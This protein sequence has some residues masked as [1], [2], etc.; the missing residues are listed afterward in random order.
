MIAN[1]WMQDLSKVDFVTSAGLYVLPDQLILVRLRKNFRRVSLTEQEARELPEGDK[2]EGISELTGWIAEDVREIA[3]KSGHESRERVLRQALLSLMPHFNAARD[4]FFIC[5]PQEQAII[6]QI[7]LPQAAE[8]NLQEVLEYEIERYVPFRREDIYY[9]FLP[10]AKKGDKIGIFLFAIPKRELNTLLEVLTSFGIK[11]KGVETT[12]TALANYLLFCTADTAV[13]ATIVGVHGQT[14]ELVGV[15]RNADT[16]KPSPELMFSHSL[17]GLNG[18]Q[19]AKRDLLQQCIGKAAR[20]Y[21][22]GDIEEVLH[23]IDGA[24]LDYEDLVAKGKPRLRGSE[25]A[26]ASVLPAVGAA[27]RGVREAQFAGNVLSADVKDTQRRGV[28]SY[29]NAAL[30]AVVILGVLAWGLSYPIKDELRLRQLQRE[31]QK[32][33]PSVEAL[34]REEEQLQRARKEE[35]FF[36]QL[37]QRRGEVLRVLDE[38]SK[39]VPMNAYLSNLRYRSGA[40][41]VQGS[42]ENASGLIPLLERSPVFENVGFNAPSNRGRD[43]RETFSLK[44]DLEKPKEKME[45]T[46]KP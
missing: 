33:E 1:R 19:G 30:L 24:S 45:K 37:D 13:P 38:L 34:R 15:Q 4:S 23:S 40:L 6:Q 31:N 22:W 2:R 10:L 44:A 36:S 7:F 28:L 16:W 11:P 20:L 17:Q 46:A 9:D 39:I 14:V 42:A 26:H 8:A 41:E 12:V 5:V 43:N 18:D 35:A 21:G 29:V 3:L 32:L 25:I 27:L